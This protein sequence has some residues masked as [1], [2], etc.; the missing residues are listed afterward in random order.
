MKAD[1]KTGWNWPVFLALMAA[2]I[3]AAHACAFFCHE[4]AHSFSAWLMGW[5]N[6]PLA[7]HYPVPGP[8]VWLLQM[9]ISENVNYAPIFA[10]GHGVQAAWI[11]IAGALVGNALITLSLS[12]WGYAAAKGKGS[13]GWAL[14]A[15]WTTVASL[16]N[17]IDYVPVRTFTSEDDMGTLERGFGWSPWMTLIVLGIPTAVALVYFLFCI[18]PETLCWAFPESMAKRTFLVVLTAFGLFGFYGASGLTVDSA[19]AHEMSWV[20]VAVFMP[21]MTL[22]GILLVRGRRAAATAGSERGK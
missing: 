5:K 3:W 13:R 20:S 21:A 1:S 16:G 4:Y 11:A 7:L 8:I 15:Y 9:G 10:S 6:D 14:F 18:Q 12:R 17:F 19:I 22:I 2:Q